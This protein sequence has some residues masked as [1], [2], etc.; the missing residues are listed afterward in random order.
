MS[1]E[2]IYGFWSLWLVPE[3]EALQQT[4]FNILEVCRNV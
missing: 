3:Q 2:Q 1:H 4:K